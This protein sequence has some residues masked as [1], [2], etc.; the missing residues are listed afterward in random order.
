MTH[1][2]PATPDDLPALAALA[3]LTFPLACPPHVTAE[4]K[5]AFIAANLTA[6][7]FAR[8]LD[9]TARDVLVGVDEAGV[10]T[11]YALLVEGE[12]ADAD[13]AAAIT[14][15]PT[16]ELSKCYVHPDH[17]GAGVAAALMAASLDAAAARE[18]AGVWLGVNQQ[19]TRAQRFYGKSGFERVGVKR[20]LVGDRY[21]DDYVFER[22]I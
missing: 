17:H 10:L 21:E 11:G 3:A 9:D 7:H 12:P 6:K 4:A 18:A 19:N 15:R 14:L 1:V 5:A 16:V 13:V 20:F 22:A 2:R 8:Y